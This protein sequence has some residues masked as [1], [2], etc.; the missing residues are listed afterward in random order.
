MTKPEN[1]QIT[2]CK[3]CGTCCKKGGPALHVEDQPLIDRGKIPVTSLFTLRKGERAFDNINGGMIQ[4]TEEIIKIKSVPEAADCVYLNQADMSCR[5]YEHRPVECRTLECWNTGKI[6]A[7]YAQTRLTRQLLVQKITWLADLVQTHE[8]QCSLERI[9]DLVQDRASDDPAAA[10]RLAEII[11]YDFHLRH[12]AA[13]KGGLPWQM[14][15]FLF[16]R[17]L[18]DI[19]SKQFGVNV[20]KAD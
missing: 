17:P 5:I 12:L 18:A 14:A 3:R 6:K 11:N 9:Q 20:R 13:E 16:G 19:I 15:D 4:L 2:S 8:H 10:S 7:I 1:H